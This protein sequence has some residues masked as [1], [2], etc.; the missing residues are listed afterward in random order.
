MDENL[1]K[2]LVSQNKTVTEIALEL[3]VSECTVRRYAKKNNLKIYSKRTQVSEELLNKINELL[4]KGLTNKEIALELQM[5]PTTVRKYTT[6]YLHKDT[7]SCR[8]KSLKKDVTLSSEQLEILYGSLLGDMSIGMQWN[9]ARFSIIHGGNQ[10]SYFDYKCSFFKGLLGKINKTPRF[11]KRTNKYYNRYSVRSKCN[12]IFTD[13]YNELYVNGI[14]TV[15]TEWLNKLTE[16]SIAFWFMDDGSNNGVIATNCFSYEEC[17]LIKDWFKNKYNIDT[18]IEC[19]KN[20]GGLQYL[21]YIKNSSKPKFYNLVKP[22]IIPD[23]E[24]K[25][26]NWIP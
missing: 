3:N 2:E 23:M 20:K 7:N 19:Q 21:I 11:D 12:K 17:S 15:T 18:T 16:R 14:K 26:K 6:V 22:Y 8:E 9:E 10:E 25:F 13:L 24:Y 1:L 5:S 4:E